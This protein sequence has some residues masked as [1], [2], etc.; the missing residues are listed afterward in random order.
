MKGRMSLVI[1]F[2][3]DKLSYSGLHEDGL[4]WHQHILKDESPDK[5]LK[6]VWVR[7]NFYTESFVFGLC[8]RIV[9]QRG[10]NILLGDVL[11]DEFSRVCD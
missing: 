4:Y 10:Q 11:K 1:F 5:F 9:L 8:Q 6:T 3:K 7:K 2:G